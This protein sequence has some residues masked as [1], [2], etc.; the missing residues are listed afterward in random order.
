M[1]RAG[2]DGRR[3]AGR[4]GRRMTVP[5]GVVFSTTGSYAT[6]GR[7]LLDGTLLAIE[8]V[9]A[10]PSFGVTLVPDFADPA[11]SLDAYRSLCEQL[12][13]RRRIRHMIGCYTS[14]SR[15]EII[16]VVEKFDSLLWYPS[17]YEGFESC[18]SVIYGGA[19]PNQHLIPAA[20]WMLPRYGRNIYCVGSNYVWPWEN[21]RIM[22]E[23]VRAC[24]GGILREKYLPIGSTDIEGV[25]RDISDL[26]PDFIF[27]TL[28]GDSCYAFYRAYRRL[29]DAD[30]RFAAERRPILSCSLSEP[31]L[32]AIGAGA[33][34][35]NIASS[36]YFQT[37]DRAENAAFIEIFR[38]RFGASR[39]TSADAEAAYVTTLLL[40]MS[41]QA[42]GTDE[43]AQ[44][45]R[46]A[47]EC[48]LEA[49]Q[50]AVRIDPENNH[51]WLTPRIGRAGA[52]GQFT[53][54]WEASAPC[55]PDPYLAHIDLR[56]I[57]PGGPWPAGPLAAGDRPHLRLVG[58][59][60]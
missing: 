34:S 20:A 43:V 56:R 39:V 2:R 35:G 38:A 6:L 40:A 12:L 51:C 24:G 53:L 32:L 55:R 19:A 30:P 5:V 50:G 27:N 11:G 15:K 25:I 16:P 57:L 41:L 14:S 29:G 33:A 8:T 58:Q 13:G 1:F 59:R 47:Y 52:G 44:V 60:P 23:I 10:S 21:N 46:A 54:E 31:E 9:N 18:D 36:V 4:G 26:K 48:R 49:P 3:M 17:H 7:D 28:I 45:K 42:A 22:R 37:V